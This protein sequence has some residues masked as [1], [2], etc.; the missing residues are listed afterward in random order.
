MLILIILIDLG[1]LLN[2]IQYIEEKQWQLTGITRGS[3]T[4]NRV[5][6]KK[7]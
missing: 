6:R 4:A 5:I 1:L 2:Y 7:I 3:M